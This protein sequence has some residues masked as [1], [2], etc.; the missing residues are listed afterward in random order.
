MDGA[1]ECL[2]IF[3]GPHGSV[4]PSWYKTSPAVPT[5]NYAVV[6]AHGF[7][8]ARP[9]RDFLDGVLRELTSQYEDHR[10]VP[11]RLALVPSDMHERM[12][13][14]IVAFEM[15]VTSLEAKYKLS[16]NRSVEDRNGTIDGLAKEG[17]A[18]ASALA[19]F[20]TKREAI[21]EKR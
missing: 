2:A 21:S 18:E 15:R 14:S 4:S 10:D 6:H 17:T 5:W 1:A 3:H 16:Q 13:S 9:E 20:M 11:W 8:R 19:D 7:L 12:A